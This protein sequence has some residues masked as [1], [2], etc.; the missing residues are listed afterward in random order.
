MAAGD[1]SAEYPGLNDIEAAAPGSTPTAGEVQMT[2]QA[3][4]IMIVM[5]GVICLGLLLALIMAFGAKRWEW[6]R[7]VKESTWAWRLWLFLWIGPFLAIQFG[8]ATA[9]VGRQPWVV[10]GELKTVDGISLA[11]PA[12]Q[13]LITIVLFVVVYL[14]IFI[15]W[16]RIFGKFVSEGP[17]ALM[18]DAKAGS[19]K[20]MQAGEAAGAADG[21]A[22][23]EGGE[24]L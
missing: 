6:A 5:M 16:I 10:F 9:E 2:F 11:V 12:E 22:V 13:L 24:T 8:W 14:V 3:Y 20:R 21:A 4:H 1:F 19:G 7:K 23:R 17:E 15:A 18:A